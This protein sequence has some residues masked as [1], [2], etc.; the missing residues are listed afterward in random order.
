M[1][2][3]IQE[4]QITCEDIANEISNGEVMVTANAVEMSDNAITYR[5]EKGPYANIVPAE[6][7][8]I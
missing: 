5:D 1:S 8:M 6:S 7:D 2:V 4:E 3:R